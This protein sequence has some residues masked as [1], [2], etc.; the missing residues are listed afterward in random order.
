LPHRLE[1]VRNIRGIKFINDS[2]GTNVGA[3]VKAIESVNDPII[4]IAGGKDKG[5]DFKVLSQLV[6]EKVRAIF[7]IG[8]ATEKIAEALRSY[9][10]IIISDN[11][12]S[13]V[14]D[15]YRMAKSGYTVLFS[16]GC[17]SF[18]MFKDYKDRGEK[19]KQIVEGLE[20]A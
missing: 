15:A 6:K 5:G 1:K 7:L 10:E 3:V 9:T 13:A 17:A 8:E 12:Q 2:K 11:L 4:L 16:P 14:Q 18:D 20:N 19:F